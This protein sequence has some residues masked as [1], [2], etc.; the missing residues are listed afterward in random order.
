MTLEIL[1]FL[2]ELLTA[3]QIPVGSPNFLATV[4][5]TSQALME[6]DTAIGALTASNGNQPLKIVG[7]SESSDAAQR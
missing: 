3:Q 6:L 2:K 5:V 4:R 1:Q 7:P